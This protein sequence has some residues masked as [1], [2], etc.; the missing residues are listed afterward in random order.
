MLWYVGQKVP[1]YLPYLQAKMVEGGQWDAGKVPTRDA[2]LS[3]LQ[4][5]FEAVDFIGAA[6]EV[7]PFLH[8]AAEVGVWGRE[9]F[10]QAVD[11]LLVEER[12]HC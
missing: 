11:S 9:F 2:L 7:A 4:S 3:L 12:A 8:D 10:S 5:R 6:A 1:V